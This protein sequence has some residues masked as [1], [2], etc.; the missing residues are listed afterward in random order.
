MSN[1]AAIEVAAAIVR[2]G[3]TILIA[4]RHENDHL[5]NLWEFPGGKREP[6]ETFE[7]CLARELQEELGVTVRVGRLVH[8]VTHI[9]P[10]RAV[11]LCFYECVLLNGEPKPLDCQDCRWVPAAELC[12]YKFPPADDE[13]IEWLTKP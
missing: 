13:L 10:E 11:R 12:R 4:Q 7:Q 1:A 2:R 6:G 9:Y 8:D 3:G 5:A